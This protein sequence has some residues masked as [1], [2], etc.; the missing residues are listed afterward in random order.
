MELTKVKKWHQCEG[1]LGRNW[2]FLINGSNVD[3]YNFLTDVF[4]IWASLWKSRVAFYP[5]SWNV[6]LQPT[7]TDSVVL[8][9][10]R[11]KAPQCCVV[12]RQGNE[13]KCV[14]IDFC[15]F[16]TIKKYNNSPNNVA[17][18][19][20]EPIAI[21]FQLSTALGGTQKDHGTPIET[22]PMRD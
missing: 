16:L 14:Q 8:L 3:F 9:V 1:Y 15:V 19:R 13:E 20:F 21:Q 6:F 7:V 5:P 12:Q 2:V 4:F 18:T 17:W 11:T 10:C 22:P